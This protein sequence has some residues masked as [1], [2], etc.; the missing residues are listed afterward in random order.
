MAQEV[1]IGT[2]VSPAKIRNPWG[3]FG[4]GFITLGIYYWF[5]WFYINREM[6][7]FG[8]NRGVDLGS[9]PGTSC[10]AMIFGGFALY[11]PTVW[12]I[13]TTSSRI[14]RSQAAA[15]TPA[16]LNGWAA[17]ALWILTLGI[18]GVI[19]TQ[20][21]INKAWETLPHYAAGASIGGGD[22]DLGRIEK[23]AGLRDSGAITQEEFDAEK[24]KVL[25]QDQ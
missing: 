16:R 1:A 3:V 21:Q 7:D 6:A 20:Y 24:S 10:V 13:V 25:P 8:R 17:A 19:Y 4:L 14:Q 11:I 12:T 23:L 5:W 18:G 22:P 15:G 9:S 2:G